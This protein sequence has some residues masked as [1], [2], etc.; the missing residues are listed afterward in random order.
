VHGELPAPPLA[1][2]GR[3]KGR[4]FPGPGAAGQGA[5]PAGQQDFGRCAVSGFDMSSSYTFIF[6]A[7]QVAM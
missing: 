3:A 6:A 7:T 4:Y 2:G 1:A 5:A